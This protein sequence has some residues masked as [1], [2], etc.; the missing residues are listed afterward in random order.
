MCFVS[1]IPG[2]DGFLLGSNRDE[3]RDRKTA[4]LPMVLE[5][6]AGRVVMP[7]DGKAGGTWIALRED[8]TAVVLLNGAFENHQRQPSYRHSRGLIIPEIMQ[9]PDPQYA[10]EKFNLYNLEPFT[11][12]MAGS[13]FLTEWRWDGE[14]L[15]HKPLQTKGLYCWSSATLYDAGQQSVREHWFRQAIGAGEIT[16]AETLLR[17][18]STGGYGPKNTDIVL[19]RADR[20]GTVSTTVVSVFKNTLQMAYQDYLSPLGPEVVQLKGLHKRIHEEKR[21]VQ[22]TD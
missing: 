16:D 11:L 13:T 21:M 2:Q 19:D 6:A 7:L 22:E 5:T 1:Y 20:I 9:Q 14:K 12:V 3:H 17:W 10:F 15:H 8:G 4:G 18:Q